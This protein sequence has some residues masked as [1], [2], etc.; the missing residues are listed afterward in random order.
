[1]CSRASCLSGIFFSP[2]LRLD[3]SVELFLVWVSVI[4]ITHMYCW[5]S[6]CG[7]EASI[8]AWRIVKSQAENK[9]AS[10]SASV[11]E[12]CLKTLTRQSH[13]TLHGWFRRE[14]EVH[15]DKAM[16]RIPA[17]ERTKRPLETQFLFHLAFRCSFRL[18]S[19]PAQCVWGHLQ[20]GDQAQKGGEQKFSFLPLIGSFMTALASANAVFTLSLTWDIC[21]CPKNVSSPG[22]G[23]V[24]ARHVAPQQSSSRWLEMGNDQSQSTRLLDFNSSTFRTLSQERPNWHF[25]FKTV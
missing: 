9:P 17:F 4:T 22:Q 13:V 6:W 20:H 8:R 7:K 19:F 21:Q 12:R 10:S 16:D 14:H 1:M 15:T 24:K 3:L 23:W 25:H 5:S 11:T 2:S 18:F